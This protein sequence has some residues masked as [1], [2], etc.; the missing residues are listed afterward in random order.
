MADIAIL[1]LTQTSQSSKG[2]AVILR[3]SKFIKKYKNT[4][5]AVMLLS[6]FHD[7][8]KNIDVQMLLQYSK[9]FKLNN[10]AKNRLVSNFEDDRPDITLLIMGSG[11]KSIFVKDIFKTKID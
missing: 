3:E 2:H 11:E 4:F 10:F 7:C 6:Q 9:T 5:V 1:E 8:C